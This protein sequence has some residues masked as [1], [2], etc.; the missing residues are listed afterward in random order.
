M[1][2]SWPRKKTQGRH[3][4]AGMKNYDTGMGCKFILL[5]YNLDFYLIHS[6]IPLS[7]KKLCIYC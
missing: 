6:V 7:L 1:L 3:Y 2:Q 5:H 4:G